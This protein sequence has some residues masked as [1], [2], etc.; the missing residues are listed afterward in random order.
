MRFKMLMKA[1]FRTGNFALLA[2]VIIVA[3]LTNFF[4]PFVLVGF[5]VYL[6]FVV[7]TL[8]SKRFI[9]EFNREIKLEG[10]QKMSWECNDL[11]RQLNRKFNKNLKSRVIGIMKQKDELMEYFGKCSDNPVKQTIIEQA[12]K[13]VEAY[14]RLVY[15]YSVRSGE[16]TS[17]NMNELTNRINYNNRRLGSLK[18]YEAVLELTK[19]VELDEKL[20][21]RMKDEKEELERAG[22]RLEYIESTIGGFKHQIISSDSSDPASEEIEDVINEAAALDNVLSERSKNRLRL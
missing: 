7:H 9:S 20:L 15:N 4:I 18:S 16:L 3:V 22:I 2:G 21:Q 8:R 5:A 17:A 10:L 12:L 13:L 11:Y 6:Y 1:A 14:L 19:T